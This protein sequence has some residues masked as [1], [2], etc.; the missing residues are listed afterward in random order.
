MA[1]KETK[2]DWKTELVEGLKSKA[3]SGIVEYAKGLIKKAQD[4][5]YYTQRKVIQL[6]YASALFI[7]GIIFLSIAIVL[8]ISDYL[9]LSKGWSFLILG[10]V[11]IILAMFVKISA[12]KS[13]Y[14]NK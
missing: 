1:K 2:K 12:E 6:F 10:L 4:A 11:L 8:L 5:V 3:L 14:Y 9:K 13:K 7:A